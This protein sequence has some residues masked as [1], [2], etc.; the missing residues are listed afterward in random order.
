MSHR[1]QISN[2]VQVP[3]LLHISEYIRHRVMV[4]GSF[5]AHLFGEDVVAFC[6]VGAQLIEEVEA[7]E[8]HPGKEGRYTGA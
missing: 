5:R 7:G 3:R 2:S 6:K 4:I 8:A 1:H